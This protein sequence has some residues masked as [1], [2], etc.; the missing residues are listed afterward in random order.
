MSAR[1]RREHE[2]HAL[3]RERTPDVEPADRL[4]PADR[5]LELFEAV[6]TTGVFEDSKTFVDCAPRWAPE[7]I[8]GRYR[9]LV[10]EP[11]FDLVRF[12][13]GHFIEPDRP[14]SGVR[15]DPGDSLRAHISRLWDELTRHPRS[16]PRAGSL[17]PLPEAYVVPGG[18]FRELYYWDSYFT[19]LGLAA[20]GRIEPIRTMTDDFAY[21]IDR[22]GHV[23]NANRSYYLSRSQPPAFVFMVLLCEAVGAA[24]PVSYLPQLE[25]EHAWWTD[26]ADGLAPGEALRHCVRLPDGA[27]LNRFWDDRDT[28]REESYRE[29]VVTASRSDRPPA[30]VYREL[31]AGAASGWDFGSRWCGVPGDLATIRTTSIVPVDLNAFLYALE[32]TIARLRLR[33]GDEAGAAEFEGL[34]DERRRAVDAW[35]W[36]EAAGAYLDHDLVEGAPRASLNAACAV[37]LWVG[38][39][40]DEQARRTA[41]AVERRLLRPGGLGTSEHETGEQWDEPN[42]WAP[43]HWMA[44]RGFR[45]H[46]LGLAEVLRE[47][48]LQSVQTVFEREGKLVEKYAMHL[49]PERTTGGGGGEYPLQDGFGWTN[50]VTAALLE[51][52]GDGPRPPG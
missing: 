1:A 14:A 20:D 39:A 35:L 45:R 43:L 7:H 40:S 26:G 31:R 21:L 41:D 50:G 51:W 30:E 12:V 42:G 34:A 38:L 2:R 15:A 11:D 32:R 46:G 16:H 25:R 13:R 28:P 37:P 33:A 3:E 49:E 18:R 24:D 10:R 22:Y 4:S 19:M 52:G 29:D 5:Y 8:L 6:Q 36:N 48:W 17:L 9:R 47:R 44:I 27:L 23:P